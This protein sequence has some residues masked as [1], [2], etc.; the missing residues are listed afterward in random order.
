LAFDYSGALT[1]AT[2][3]GAAYF[4][5]AG[6]KKAQKS[7]EKQAAALAATAQAE[8]RIAEANAAAAF[9]PGAQV[10]AP[11]PPILNPTLLAGGVALLVVA[12]L[13]RR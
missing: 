1:G 2:N 4:N 9:A 11:G 12:L 8:A 6:Q 13:L 3:V 7:A 5:Y 10:V